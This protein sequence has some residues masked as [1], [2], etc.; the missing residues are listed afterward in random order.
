QITFRL[1]AEDKS[2]L[3]EHSVDMQ[4]WQP[5]GVEEQPGE[6]NGWKEMILPRGEKSHGFYRA[7]LFS[8][9]VGE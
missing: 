6:E 2:Y 5:V 8:E 1:K 4:L 9:L 7:K 3:I